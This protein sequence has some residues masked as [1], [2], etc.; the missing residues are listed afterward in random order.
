MTWKNWRRIAGVSAVFCSIAFSL[1]AFFLIV[2]FDRDGLKTLDEMLLGTSVF[3]PD[4]DGDDLNDGVEVHDYKT[5]PLSTD[6]DEDGLWDGAEVLGSWH[7]FGLKSRPG[8]GINYGWTWILEHEI[9]DGANFQKYYSWPG[10]SWNWPYSGENILRENGLV[11]LTSNPLSID[12]DGD[13]MNDMV[14]YE[15]GTNPRSVDTDNDGLEDMA[16]VK[17]NKM[18][19]IFY[20][21]DGDLLGDGEE[22]DKY[23]TDPLNWDT[24]YDHLSDGVELKGYDVDGDGTIDVNFPAFGANPRVRDIFVEVD[25][26]PGARTLES[27]SKG[28]LIEAFAQHG[29]VLHIDQGELGGGSETKESVD[30]LYDNKDGSMDDFNDFRQKYFTASRRGI[31]FWCLITNSETYAYGQQV[32]GFNIGDSFT[33]SGKWSSDATMGS[34]FM[35][36]LGHALGLDNSIFD[37]IDSEKYSFNRYG[38]VMNYNAPFFKGGEFY[39]YSNGPPFNDWAHLNF[40]YL[41]GRVTTK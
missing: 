6:T 24:D 8:D 23:S 29:M 27:Y 21:T 28:K 38:S 39:D 11:H 31:F 25:W 13:G 36:E 19:P 37:G 26:M 35:H 40:N 30:I 12:T 2:D 16:E 17:T 20:D 18:I 7:T 33:L 22:I 1:I 3:N 41:S 32:G 14:E 34:A 10:T 5:N 4:T 15:I 9:W